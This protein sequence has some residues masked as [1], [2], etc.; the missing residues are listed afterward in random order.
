[1]LIQTDVALLSFHK[2]LATR[3]DRQGDQDVRHVLVVVW[4]RVES[5]GTVSGKE[6]R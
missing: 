1:M 6:H 2:E 3:E 4:I 5:H